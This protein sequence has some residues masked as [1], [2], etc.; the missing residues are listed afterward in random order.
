MLNKEFASMKLDAR[1]KDEAKQ[2]I[3]GAEGGNPIEIS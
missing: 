2:T 1:Q 3:Q